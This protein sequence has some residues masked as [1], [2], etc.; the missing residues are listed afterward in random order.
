MDIL[1]FGWG[2]GRLALPYPK[3]SAGQVTGLDVAPGMI[4]IANG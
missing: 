3:K 4:K 1:D 2:M